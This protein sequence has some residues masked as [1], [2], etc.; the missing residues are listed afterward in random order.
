MSREVEGE[1][2]GISEKTLVR[3]ETRR[4]RLVLLSVLRTV[5]F[6]LSSPHMRCCVV[7]FRMW[8]WRT[9][10]LTLGTTAPTWLSPTAAD[11]L[12]CPSSSQGMR[13]M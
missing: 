11:P 4:H 3:V 12:Y 1:I 5:M 10:T 6:Q 9:I 2:K 7:C 13:G 8:V